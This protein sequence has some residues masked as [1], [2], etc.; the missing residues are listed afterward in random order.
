MQNHSVIV[1]VR[2]MARVIFPFIPSKVFRVFKWF[3]MLAV[4]CFF[5]YMLA[6][7]KM[8]RCKMRR[9]IA[10]IHLLMLCVRSG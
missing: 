9:N 10:E 7:S 2:I 6:S 3:V 4:I 8:Q 1:K 5:H